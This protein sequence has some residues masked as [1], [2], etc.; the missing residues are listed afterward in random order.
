[1]GWWSRRSPTTRAN[2]SILTSFYLFPFSVG[3]FDFGRGELAK[4]GRPPTRLVEAWLHRDSIIEKNPQ[5][6]FKDESSTKRNWKLHGRLGAEHVWSEHEECFK[7]Y[8]F[9][10]A[11]NVRNYRDFFT[12]SEEESGKYLLNSVLGQC[13]DPR[14][15]RN[16]QVS[17]DFQ[18]CNFGD[19]LSHAQLGN[20]HTLVPLWAY[21]D[22][23]QGGN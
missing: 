8:R 6:N 5:K 14:R 18:F 1:M 3:G 23:L 9:Q 12:K 17:S 20:A 22:S 10:N 21:K 19:G 7:V 15:R 16:F 2:F 13:V 11:T 4:L